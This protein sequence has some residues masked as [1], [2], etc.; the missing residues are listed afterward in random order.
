MGY[1]G[2]G[3]WGGG[4]AYFGGTGGRAQSEGTNCIGIAGG[5]LHPAV[6]FGVFGTFRAP[7]PNPCLA[8]GC[9]AAP[10][11]LQHLTDLCPCGTPGDR[12]DTD[13]PGAPTALGTTE[14]PMNKA[15]LHP[16]H[17]PAWGYGP[18]EWAGIPPT[19]PHCRALHL[20]PLK[21]KCCRVWIWGEKGV[22]WD[23]SSPR[24]PLHPHCFGHPWA[25]GAPSEHW[26]PGWVPLPTSCFSS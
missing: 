17:H 26:D 7:F 16:R 20:L 12:G 21:N 11:E 24:C 9:D 23:A 15:S 1:L 19:P 18:K 10:K 13:N 14:P 22:F 6:L 4:V 3:R 2:V 25:R 5:V 8:G